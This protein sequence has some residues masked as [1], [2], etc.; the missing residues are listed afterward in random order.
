MRVTD[1]GVDTQ[2]AQ[3]AQEGD[4]LV[5]DIVGFFDVDQATPSQ[6]EERLAKRSRDRVARRVGNDRF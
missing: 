1:D 4:G 3:L 6:P 5:T 2:I